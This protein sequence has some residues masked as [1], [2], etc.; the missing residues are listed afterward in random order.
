MIVGKSNTAVDKRLAVVARVVRKMDRLAAGRVVVERIVGRIA[1]ENSK[2]DRPRRSP[3]T[4]HASNTILT[5][6]VAVVRRDDER[7]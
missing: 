6:M 7:H 2:F 1:V 5:S 4:V 3:S